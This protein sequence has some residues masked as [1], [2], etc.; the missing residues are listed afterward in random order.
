MKTT[1]SRHFVC[2]HNSCRS[3]HKWQEGWAKK[4]K[5]VTFLE[6]Y[7]VREHEN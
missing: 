2:V 3:Q 7:S 6:V 5:G 4:T 1:K